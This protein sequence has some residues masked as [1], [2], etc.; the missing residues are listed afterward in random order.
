MAPPSPTSPI[1]CV[2]DLFFRAKIV[3]VAKTMNI[4]LTIISR[5]E[6]ATPTSLLL[7]DVESVSMEE[8][9]SC[10]KHFPKTKIVGFLSHVNST[11]RAEAE[12]AGIRALTKSLFFQRLPEILKGTFPSHEARV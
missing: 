8:I 2:R 3:E 1:V 9:H 11:L 7:L 12:A 4:S 6:E 10:V 5:L